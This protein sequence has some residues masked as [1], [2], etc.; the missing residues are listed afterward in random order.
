VGMS[1]KYSGKP[2]KTDLAISQG[3]LLP[4]LIE[5]DQLGATLLV[6]SA[7]SKRW[8]PSFV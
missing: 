5:G 8:E 6:D 3:K 2:R 1:Q 7:I 4:A